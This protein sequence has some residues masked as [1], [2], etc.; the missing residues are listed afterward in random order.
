MP[1]SDSLSSDVG[2][3]QGRGSRTLPTR[4]PPADEHE[5]QDGEAIGGHHQVS[6]GNSTFMAICSIS[7]PTS[8]PPRG[9]LTTMMPQGFSYPIQATMM[10]V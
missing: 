9:T 2:H 6:H 1:T 10:A 7:L 4:L 5:S 3:P 8:S